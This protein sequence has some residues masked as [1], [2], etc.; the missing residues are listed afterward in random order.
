MY[1]EEALGAARPPCPWAGS[2]WTQ[3]GA[4]VWDNGSVVPSE[5]STFTTFK[6][7]LITFKGHLGPFAEDGLQLSWR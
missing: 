6:V 1:G 2:R 7:H 4:I 3:A 5:G